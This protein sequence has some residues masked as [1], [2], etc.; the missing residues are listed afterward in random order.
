MKEQFRFGHLPARKCLGLHLEIRCLRRAAQ[1][2]D[3]KSPVA[4]Q[5]HVFLR[6]APSQMD[7]GP[8]ASR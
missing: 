4:E 2:E 1:G 7:E 6:R 3:G 5:P 8:L